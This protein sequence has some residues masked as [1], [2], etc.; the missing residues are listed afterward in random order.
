MFGPAGAVPPPLKAEVARP[1]LRPQ[2]RYAGTRA[3]LAVPA[4]GLDPCH[5]SNVTDAAPTAEYL[6]DMRRGLD[7][8]VEIGPM[9]RTESR[10]SMSTRLGPDGAH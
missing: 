4:A 9:S 8:E 2:V 1:V 10:L 6:P 7:V 5:A 3:L